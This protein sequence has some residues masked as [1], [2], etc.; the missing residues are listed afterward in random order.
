MLNLAESLDG[1]TILGESVLKNYY[2]MFD[3]EFDKV[4]FGLAKTK[5]NQKL[6]SAIEEEVVETVKE[7]V[8]ETEEDLEFILRFWFI[9][10]FT[11]MALVCFRK[12]AFFA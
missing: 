11:I 12:S 2:W 9:I 7:V 10:V 5:Y 1:H 3:V 6:F 4:G 8:K